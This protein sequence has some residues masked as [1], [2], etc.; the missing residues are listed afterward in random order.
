MKIQAL[1]IVCTATFSN[2]NGE[3]EMREDQDGCLESC[4]KGHWYDEL[5]DHCYQWSNF[6]DTWSNAEMICRQKLKGK[7]GHLAAVT[8]K[9]IHELLM[10]KV[11]PIDKDTWYWVGGSDTDKENE[12]KWTDGSK[13]EFTKW[14]TSPYQ[15]PYKSNKTKYTKEDC[16]QIYHNNHAK[17]GWN[18][19]IC[20]KRHGFICSWRKCENYTGPK[21]TEGETLFFSI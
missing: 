15:Q 9:E 18:D 21:L 6:E 8:N 4:M 16:L 14:A 5:G 1:F 17:N 10:K 13:W 11:I 19:Q 12:W 20:D 2:Q 3:K 7:G